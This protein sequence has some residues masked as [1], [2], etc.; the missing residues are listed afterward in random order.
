MQVDGL[1]LM[2]AGGFVATFAGL[3]VIVAWAQTRGTTALLWWGAG[4]LLNAVATI[5]L[6]AGMRATLPLGVILRAPGI[7]GLLIAF[8]L[9]GPACFHRRPFSVVAVAVKCIQRP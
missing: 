6:A 1:T 4:H 2:V 9:G 8:L 3:L 5:V 7:V